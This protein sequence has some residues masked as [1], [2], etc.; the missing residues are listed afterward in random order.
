MIDVE[1]SDDIRKYE[2]KS[3]GMFTPRQFACIVLGLV[4]ALPIGLILPIQDVWNKIIVIILLALPIW[5]C[6]YKI[7]GTN[8]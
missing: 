4:V 3:I 2:T 6:G 8:F 5:L 7:N 1:M